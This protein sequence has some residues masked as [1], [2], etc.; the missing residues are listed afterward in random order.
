MLET[1]SAWIL[2]VAGEQWADRFDYL[3]TGKHLA[4]YASARFTI[5]AAI[6][7]A[8]LAVL[9]GLM[10][11]AMRRSGIAPVRWLGLA[12]TT[13]I[14]GVPDVLFILFLPLAFEQL[15]EFVMAQRACSAEEL[16][17]TG[18]WPPCA[19]AQWYLSTWHYFTLACFSLGIVYGAFAANVIFGAM[20]AVPAGQLEAARAFGFSRR[21]VFWRF[22]V[23]QMWIY[24]LPGLS[25]VWMLLLKATAFLSLLQIADI[26]LWAER[27]GAP[28]Y[29]ARAGLVHPDWRWRYYLVLFLFYILL[30]LL[31]ERVFNWLQRRASRG[32]AVAG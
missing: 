3:T 16:A 1:L 14:R 29:F 4:W 2:S 15:V 30:T 12:Y 7:S 11:A 23:R 5:M 24:A 17:A 18:K 10:G 21:Q 31:S 8:I 26:V 32:L 9:F 25:N 28:N 27:L 22:Q 20:N 6:F 19:A 13:M